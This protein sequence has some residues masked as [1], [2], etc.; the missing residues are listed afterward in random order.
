METDMEEKNLSPSDDKGSCE[1]DKTE[2]STEPTAVP[3]WS[4]LN[5]FFLIGNTTVV[6]E[7]GTANADVLKDLWKAYREILWQISVCCDSKVDEKRSVEL[8]SERAKQLQL[9]PMLLGDRVTMMGTSLWIHS[10]HHTVL[11]LSLESGSLSSAS[12]SIGTALAKVFLE[13]FSFL[14][15]S[16]STGVDTLLSVKCRY[17]GKVV[18]DMAALTF[19]NRS[20]CCN[21]F[22]HW[23]VSCSKGPRLREAFARMLQAQA[24]ELEKKLKEQEQSESTTFQQVASLQHL[25]IIGFVVKHITLLVLPPLDLIFVIF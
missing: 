12:K 23:I 14:G 15:Y 18:S 16:T 1:G 2:K 17:L 13:A 8:E 19:D 10:L 4:M 20:N 25:Y 5:L 6:S 11:E 24:K 3:H 22:V 9:H 21:W 7:L